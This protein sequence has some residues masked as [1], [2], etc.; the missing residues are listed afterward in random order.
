MNKLFLRKYSVDSV[1]KDACLQCPFEEN[2]PLEAPVS[3]ESLQTAVT[4]QS[5][6]AIIYAHTASLAAYLTFKTQID[7][8][9]VVKG[10]HRCQEYADWH[11]H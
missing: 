10:I 4:H 8:Q 3:A 2:R 1:A 5:I 9:V 6:Q 7:Q 11:K